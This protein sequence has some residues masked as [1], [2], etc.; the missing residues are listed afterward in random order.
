MMVIFLITKLCCVESNKPKTV[1]CFLDDFH[2]QHTFDANFS[3]SLSLPLLLHLSFAA[4]SFIL[5]LLAKRGF[6]FLHSFPASVECYLYHSIADQLLD[7]MP[8][9]KFSH[10]SNAIRRHTKKRSFVQVLQVYISMLRHG[11]RANGSTF[12]SILKACTEL[13]SLSLG[14]AIHAHAILLGFE[15]ATFIQNGIIVMYAKFGKIDVAREVFDELSERNV[16]SWTSIISGCAHN[17]FAL[18]AIKIFKTMRKDSDVIPDFIALV[19]VL[20]A[21]TDVGDLEQGRC[22]HALALKFGLEDEPDLLVTLTSMYAKCGQV[23]TARYLF[24]QVP[25]VDVILWN[26]MIS[27]YAKN[28]HADEAVVLFK[29]MITWKSRPDSIT[30]RS[31]IL[32]CAQVGSL[33]AARWIWEF[34]RESEFRDDTFVNTAIIDMFAKCGSMVIARCIFDNIPHKDVVVWSAMIMGYGLHG[35]GN[36]AIS[37]FHEMVQ[38]KVMPN[39]VTFIGLLS[40]CKHSGFVEE[41]RKYFYSMR[42]H[43]VEPRHQHYACIVDL[44]ARSGHLDEAYE[45]IRGMPMAPEVTVWGA[46]LNGCRIYGHVELGKHAAEQ[47][48]AIEPHNAGHYVQLSNIFASARMWKDV[49]NVRVLMKERGVNKATGFSS[50][51]VNGKLQSFFAG[52]KSHPRSKEIFAMLGELEGMLR[53]SG[54]VPHTD[55]ALHDLSPE[56]MEESLC[57]HSERIAIAYGLISTTPGTTLRITKNLRACVNCHSAT[58]FISKLVKREIVVRDAN[59][60]HHFKDGLCSCRDYW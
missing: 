46:L 25:S 56:E 13:T 27:G 14:L 60:F 24:D 4:S 9:L 6:Q 58:K 54:F 8:Q 31:A 49:A 35:Q 19:S 2:F 5:S 34:V 11:I 48:F 3:S 45:F 1:P 26:A 59:R 21:F 29:K 22:V 43:A 12:P 16:V 15:A 41:G 17:G 20:K 47:V 53:K 32:A 52:D 18:E 40:A 44:L 28:G 38:S 39:D 37:L 23:H 57:N 10:F 30:L 50:I 51:D 55:S 42:D 36:E 7:E 33:E